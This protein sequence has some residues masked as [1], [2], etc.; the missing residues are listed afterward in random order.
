[1]T[2]AA[3]E[4][5]NVTVTDADKMASLLCRLFDWQIRWRGPGID[6]GYS[7]HVGT[8]HAYLAVYSMNSPQT[9]SI[10]KHAQVGGLN[11]VG[12]VVDDLDA[13]E[14]RVIEEGF[15]T[16][17]HADYEP[18]RRFYFTGPDNVEFEVV[19]YG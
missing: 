8:E 19:S 14:K 16:H 4:H 17:S 11:H 15:T 18:G 3:L 10:A 7:I 5:I 6:D 2:A 12:V 9:S 13:M 1:M